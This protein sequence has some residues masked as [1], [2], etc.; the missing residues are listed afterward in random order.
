MGLGCQITRDKSGK[1]QEVRGF[2]EAESKL[3]NSIV[4][5][6][7]ELTDEEALR[8]YARF[9]TPTFRET[10]GD[11]TEGESVLDIDING[12]PIYNQD[13]LSKFRLSSKLETGF[14]KDFNITVG[15]FQAIHSDLQRSKSTSDFLGKVIETPNRTD[16]TKEAVFFAYSMLGKENGK[17]KADL[18]YTIKSWNKYEEK[19]DL[20]RDQINDAYGFMPDKKIWFNKVRDQ[21]IID[22][23][24][25][26]LVDF[27]NNPKSFE[28][29]GREKF[30][31]EDWHKGNPTDV[32]G[33]FLKWIRDFFGK[34][35]KNSARHQ[36]IRLTN[37]AVNIAHE[38]INQEYRIFNYGLTSDQVKRE[39]DETINTDPVAKRIVDS[40][41][42]LGIVLTGSLALRAQGEVYRTKDELI[43]DLDFTVPFSK[44]LEQKVLLDEL[45][46]YKGPDKNIISDAAIKILPKYNWFKS[47]K[48]QF[49]DFT[50]TNAFTS[51]KE[52]VAL[53]GVI[54]G[55]FYD[56]KGTHTEEVD[57]EE[58]TVKHKKGEHKKGTGYDI[59]FFIELEPTDSASTKDNFAHWKTIFLAKMAIGARKKDLVDLKHFTPFNQNPD[60][61]TFNTPLLS[62][63][64]DLSIIDTPTANEELTSLTL[65]DNIDSP[66]PGREYADAEE[67]AEIAALNYNEQLVNDQLEALSRNINVSYEIISSREAEIIT[68]DTA[69]P[70]SGEP[71]FFF[72][73]KVYFVGGMVT[74]ETAFH[75]FSHPLV[76]YIKTV[77]RP[78]FEKLFETTIKTDEGLSILDESVGE[79]FNVLQEGVEDAVKEE[80]I[81]KAL[82]LKTLLEADNIAASKEFTSIVSKIMYYIK[83]S[84]R[85]L[86]G[87]KVKIEKLDINTSLNDLAKMLA[88]GDKFNV[89]TQLIE[90]SDIVS[91][92]KQRENFQQDLEKLVQEGKQEMLGDMVDDMSEAITQLHSMVKNNKSFDNMRSALANEAGRGYLSEMLNIRVYSRTQEALPDNQRIIEGLQEAEY[93]NKKANTLINNI[94]SMDHMSD[95]IREYLKDIYDNPD[96]QE[97]MKEMYQYNKLLESWNKWLV[98]GETQLRALDAQ[99]GTGTLR[100]LLSSITNK[101][102]EIDKVILDKYA[103][104][105]SEII[106]M[107]N[108]MNEVLE[109]NH[110]YETNRL[111]ALIRN[112]S[113]LAKESYQLRLAEENAKFEENYLSDDK[114]KLLLAGATK[115]DNHIANAWLINYI[116]NPDP[117]VGSF[118]KY[119]KDAYNDVQAITHAKYNNFVNGMDDV[120]KKYGY[121]QTNFM[122]MSKDV[123]FEDETGFINPETNEFET[124]KVQTFLNDFK[125]YKR[126]LI[127]YTFILNKAKEE[128]KRTGSKEAE[129]AYV[130]I[131][132]KTDKYMQT[133]FKSKYVDDFYTK[134]DVL[135]NTVVNINGEDVRVG[136]IAKS[137][138]DTILSH[139]RDI[140]S[141]T[142]FDDP[143]EALKA[144]DE[145]KVYWRQYRELFST[146]IGAKDKTGLDLEIAKALKI[147]RDEKNKFYEWKPIAGAFDTALDGA[148]AFIEQKLNNLKLEGDEYDE[149]YAELRQAWLDGHTRTKIKDEF[150]A[151]RGRILNLIKEILDNL[152]NKRVAADPKF[153]HEPLTRFEDK[154]FNINET[155]AGKRDDDGQPVGTD[156]DDESIAYIKTQ[157]EDMIKA[158]QE[159]VKLSGLT[160]E[161]YDEMS[162]YYDY[163]KGKNARTGKKN[164]L[165][166]AEQ[167]RFDFLK[168]KK[169]ALGLDPILKSQL[170]KAFSDLDA[171]QS[172][173]PTEY[174]MDDANN[175]YQDF[176]KADI[177][178]DADTEL[179]VKMAQQL[180]IPSVVDKYSEMNADFKEW[181]NANHVLTTKWDPNLKRKV[182]VYERVHVWSVVRPSDDKYFEKTEVTREDGSVEMIDGVPNLQY[183][184]RAVKPEFMTGYNAKTGN[185]ELEIGVHKD[186]K[187]NWLP[188][189]EEEMNNKFSQD[190]EYFKT[191]T[192]EDGK[193]LSHLQYINT[194]YKAL[195]AR[196]GVTLD[197]LNKFKEYTELHEESLSPNERLGY[198][199]PRFRKDNYEY[200]RAGSLP[201]ESYA[202]RLRAMIKGIA[203]QWR[204]SKDNLEQD[205]SYEDE[206]AVTNGLNTF[207]PD[208][209][210]VPIAGKY[211][212]DIDQVSED[213]MGSM[214][215]RMFSIEQHAMLKETQHVAHAFKK[216]INELNPTDVLDVQRR[217]SPNAPITTP[218]K[219]NRAKAVNALYDTWWEGQKT[220][221]KK[222]NAAAH[223]TVNNLL[224]LAS[225]SFFALDVPSALKNY[226]G[227]QF[228]IGT[229][230][231]LGKTYVDDKGVRRNYITYDNYVK[232]R[233]WAMNVNKD[234]SMHVYTSTS[235]P[236]MLQL[237]EVMDP[238]QGRQ[239]DKFG[240]SPSRSLA[241]DVAGMTWLTSH[242]KWLENLATLEM[243]GGMMKTV[244]V[245]Q[246]INGVPTEIDYLDA[247]QL[248]E[249]TQQIEL[250]PGISK[251]WGIGGKKFKLWKNRSHELSGFN[252]GLY[253]EMDMPMANRYLAFKVFVTMRKFFTKMFL[254]RW[255]AKNRSINPAKWHLMEEKW[256]PAM[257][258]YHMGY[259]MQAGR[260]AMRIIRS[261]GDYALHM[262]KE[263]RNAFLRV[264]AEPL[265]AYAFTLLVK[266]LF[267]LWDWDPDDK[268]RW[269]KMRARSGVL[270]MGALTDDEWEKDFDTWGWVQNHA[271]LTMLNVNQENTFFYDPGQQLDIFSTSS[272][273]NGATV[274]TYWKVAELTYDAISGDES[275][276]YKKD[277]GGMFFQQGGSSKVWKQLVKLIGMK[278]KFAD[279]VTAAKNFQSF[280]K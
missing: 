161:E 49:P 234:I 184:Y 252:Q 82:T 190:P 249:K 143:I 154:W 99:E 94:I 158:K 30:T 87:S 45:L 118:G 256:N 64:R 21:I 223:K 163:M 102:D 166:K 207:R 19:F 279:P 272:I 173:V 39:Y 179:T 270:P 228:Q 120:L 52:V 114:L 138:V 75:E 229:E 84:F 121:S 148:E 111:E 238:I 242:R 95:K 134:D 178:E 271:L 93:L 152:E 27:Y 17:L 44:S 212:L 232:G 165:G 160:E 168:E 235:K 253:A 141:D 129:Q 51:S 261:G 48:K 80:V 244:K 132:A 274:D 246:T 214:M 227:A 36:R 273:I 146:K 67:L 83:Q 13:K 7:P 24:S 42:A 264:A 126:D 55:E 32:I 22:F 70:Y 66:Y 236:L 243:F 202:G 150:Y 119:L 145:K 222:E 159:F 10:F 125:G 12:E 71:A 136:D 275:A 109:R 135:L 175:F 123:L 199:L 31:K 2:N 204:S 221:G 174:Y 15:E 4:N 266:M 29:V 33:K 233:S 112:S 210:A 144:F 241:R 108:P 85:K 73:N 216:L 260:A 53:Q 147:W 86:F 209:G 189:S 34:F 106:H 265:K 47:F 35:T 157:Q 43:H 149:A 9:Y 92:M 258:D 103:E 100:S 197:L 124:Y 230:A 262:N 122:T 25:E 245:T 218:N 128:F 188:K 213:I 237:L 155:I 187:G 28:E 151:E 57:G 196:G 176:I 205:I 74:S 219:R 77:N 107:V 26:E 91:Y 65:D 110:K 201:E 104:G 101:L 240:D 23:L 38:M 231:L 59:D 63:T 79:Y 72:N 164:R 211:K 90:A 60:G 8:H 62:Y 182:Q 194:D 225:H 200:I 81:V 1:I 20:Y 167:E 153:A 46:G 156:M 254:N 54:N 78:L 14:L 139:I 170:L 172:K 61:V 269:K 105:I 16:I 268:D 183:F 267:G 131:K 259:Y 116:G 186:A 226:F 206:W 88:Q 142:K 130:E 96:Q 257:E 133:F 217:M 239:A 248:N 127:K 37:S 56:S 115:T 5:E 191:L 58:V 203:A 276:Y 117:I 277:T 76:R 50:F 263:E 6:H 97:T 250:K 185:I 3:Y 137:K 162:Y 255:S 171:L 195:K 98:V 220:V 68:E 89:D 192:D 278:G 181:H 113:G 193:P 224:G 18:K 169:G 280:N 40:A 215:K 180:L 41:R 140:D 177:G 11:F 251:E 198:E 247:W 208:G 69:N